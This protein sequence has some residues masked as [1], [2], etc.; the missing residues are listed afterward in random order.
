MFAKSSLKILI[1]SLF[2]AGFNTETVEDSFIFKF[3]TMA[4]SS[5]ATSVPCK[6]YTQKSQNNIV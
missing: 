6:K 1:V 2:Q 5:I 3:S 4:L